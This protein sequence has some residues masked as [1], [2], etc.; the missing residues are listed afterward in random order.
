MTEVAVA[1]PEQN[2][3]PPEVIETPPPAPAEGEQ[4]ASVEG[5]EEKKT[6]DEQPEKRTSR[7]F[8]RRLDN[9]YRKYGLEKARADLLEQ[10]LQKF[11]QPAPATSGEPRLQDFDDIEKYAQAKSEF[12]AEQKLKEFQAKQAQE[13]QSREVQQLVESWEEKVAEA[14]DKWDDFSEVVGDLKPDSHLTAALMEADPALAY[15]LGKNPA[16]ARK[17]ADLTPRQQLVALG[18]L[19][20]KLEAA[21]PEAKTPSKAPPPI[22]PVQTK[23]A[24]ASEEISDDDDMRTFIR[25]REKQLGRRK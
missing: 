5:T 1:A 17:I 4:K 25:K 24:P 14:S 11:K 18:K 15:H 7:R 22:T 19:A 6:T 10:E 2:A 21:P 12:K 16:E 8:E 23:A 9:A 3:P 13:R 20:A